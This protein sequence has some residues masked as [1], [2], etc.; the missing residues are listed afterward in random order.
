MAGSSGGCEDVEGSCSWVAMAVE[1]LNDR[2]PGR[3][4]VTDSL[5]CEFSA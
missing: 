1:H 2:V 3:L 4:E 5:N